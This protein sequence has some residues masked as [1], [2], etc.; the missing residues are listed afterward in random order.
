MKNHYLISVSIAFIAF[1][2]VF[3]LN[4]KVNLFIT[5]LYR[6]IMA[7]LFFFV[8]SMIL[9][10]IVFTFE[11]KQPK[12]KGNHV[13]VQLDEAEDQTLYDEIYQQEQT[14]Q[15]KEKLFKPMEFEKVEPKDEHKVEDY[16]KGIRSFTQ[17]D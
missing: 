2:I 5:S 7:F 11:M 6:G 17:D 10:S 1:I 8:L 4:W 9:Y 3:L 14:P 12:E 13:D 15:E 16:V